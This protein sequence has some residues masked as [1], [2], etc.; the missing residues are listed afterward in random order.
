ML[1]VCLMFPGWKLIQQ[2]QKKRGEIFLSIP[3]TDEAQE[4]LGTKKER[5]RKVGEATGGP[6][7]EAEGEMQMPKGSLGNWGNIQRGVS[8]GLI[9]WRR[10]KNMPTI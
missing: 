2:I 7:L 1:S 8:V 5:L 9:G 10:D 3:N 6:Q 4:N